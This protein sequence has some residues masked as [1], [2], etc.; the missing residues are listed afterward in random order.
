L[1]SYHLIH[2]GVFV[3]ETNTWFMSTAHDDADCEL[4]V[5]ALRDALQEIATEW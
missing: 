1:L 3:C 4:V 5:D 2:R